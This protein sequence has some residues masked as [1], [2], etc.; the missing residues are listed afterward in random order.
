M[1]SL[2]EQVGQAGDRLAVGDGVVERLGE[3]GRDQ[4]REVG[5]LGL[6]VGVAVAVD[7]DDVAVVLDRHDAVRVHA[8]GAYRVVERAGV[9]DELAL[10]E[11]AGQR[12][13]DDGRHLDPHADVDRVGAHRDAQA[14]ALVD[15]P[16]RALAPGRHDHGVGAVA[17]AVGAGH[18]GGHAVAYGDALDRGAGAHRDARLEVGAHGL[19]DVGRRGRCPCGA[20]AR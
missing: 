18:A 20:P 11:H 7:G 2:A 6:A 17:A 10:V 8:E 9:V 1:M 12:L 3:V 15:E 4:Q 16:G 5:V 19:E 13:H 14:V